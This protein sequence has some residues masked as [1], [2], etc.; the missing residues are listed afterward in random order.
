MDPELIEVV[1]S[2]LKEMLIEIALIIAI[3]LFIRGRIKASRKTSAIRRKIEKESPIYVKDYFKSK[4]LFID[5]ETT[6]LPNDFNRPASDDDNWPRAIQISWIVTEKGGN[7]LKRE[8]HIIRPEGFTIPEDAVKIHGI[9]TERALAEGE[10]LSS[11]LDVL[12]NDVRGCGLCVGHNVQFDKKVIGSE[13]LRTSQPDCLRFLPS[14]DTMRSSVVYCNI[15]KWKGGYRY[16]KLSKLYRK[17]FGHNFEG[18]HDSSAD[19]QATMECFFKLR[20]M[21]YINIE[22]K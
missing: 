3:V 1:E 10:S 14:A 12:S 4:I 8:N 20:E 17:L 21:G 7:V 18:A 5:T 9:T 11:V 22:E 19:V 2:S 13:Y 16:P 15:R 6:G